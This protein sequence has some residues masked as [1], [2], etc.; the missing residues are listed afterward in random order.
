MDSRAPRTCSKSVVEDA[1]SDNRIVRVGLII[2]I[3]VF[4]L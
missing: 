3:Q 2:A 4:N 1:E